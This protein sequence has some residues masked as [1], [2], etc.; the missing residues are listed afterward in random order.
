[1][2]FVDFCSG[3]GGGRLGL[4]LNGFKCLGYSEINENAIIT[5][6]TLHECEDED[7]LG[8]VTQINAKNMLDF[9]LMIAGF[10]CQSFSINGKREG[11]CNFDNGQII[12]Y[13]ANILKTKKPKFFILE[14]VKGLI[15]HEQG[16]SLEIILKLLKKSGYNV[17][18]KVL[19]SINFGLPQSRERVYFI[20]IREDLKCKFEFKDILM[21]NAN[22]SEFLSPSQKNL[23]DKKSAQYKTFLKYLN[24][25][26]NIGKFELSSILKQ[27]FL[28]LDTRQ[29]DL[30]LYENKVP[31]IRRDR[32]GILYVYDNNLY[33]LSGLEALRLQGFGAIQKIE[34][35]TA[36]L[37]N[38]NLLKQS[39]NAMSV[40][41]IKYLGS[42][43]K[44]FNG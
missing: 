27:N 6:K 14:N 23:F 44:E 33:K 22:I 40:N 8:D 38:S 42:K 4:E 9:D 13:L 18:Y 12:F 41:V 28:I 29:S 39:G 2:T 5:Y 20:G 10:P 7:F 25:K 3:I 11:L 37:S 36:N 34:E 15:N 24:N 21:Q 16:K 30:R 19:N 1:M 26:Y 35:K 17:S 31:T 43:I 32:Q